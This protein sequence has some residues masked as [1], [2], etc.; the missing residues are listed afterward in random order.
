MINKLKKVINGVNIFE[1][2]GREDE[3]KENPNSLVSEGIAFRFS[4][5]L[6]AHGYEESPMDVYN[7]TSGFRDGNRIDIHDNYPFFD[8][9]LEITNL[10]TVNGTV[11]A[12]LIDRK[13]DEYY[14]EFEIP[15]V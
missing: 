13:K 5:W 15:A 14:G 10:Y 9:G 3:G 6:E 4:D 1:Y 2:S 8:T 11:W 12:V 7:N